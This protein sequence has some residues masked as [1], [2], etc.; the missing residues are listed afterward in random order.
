[1]D[2]AGDTSHDGIIS[3]LS[4]VEAQAKVHL[5]VASRQPVTEDVT[6]R[7]PPVTPKKMIL[8]MKPATHGTDRKGPLS[9]DHAA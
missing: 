9:C 2:R 8:R 1:V 7:G 6:R 3:R 5:Q 4:G